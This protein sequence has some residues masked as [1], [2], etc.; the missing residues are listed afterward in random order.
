MLKVSIVG[1]GF[2]GKAVD[3]GFTGTE[4]MIIDPLYGND[5]RDLKAFNPNVTFV[6]VPTPMGENGQI[7]SSIV[8]NTV[9]YL[10]EKVIGLI[11]IKSTVTPDV[12]KKLTEGFGSERVIYNPEF[13]TEKNANE[14]FINPKMHIFGGDYTATKKLEEIYIQYSMCKPCQVFHMSA[15]DASFVKYGINCFLAS[16]VLW[17]NQ[18]YD[19]VEAFGGN[20][21]KI[22]NAIGS[23]GR[24]TNSHTRVPGFDGK[25]GYG[26]ACFPK[27]TSAF[28]SFAESVSPFTVLEHIIETNNAYRVHYEK[29][30]REKAQ[31]V[32]YG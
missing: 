9:K 28:A 12:V 7:D 29:D 14:D 8:E 30:E 23:D 21:R 2:V 18:F 27:D 4:K 3:Y 22:V 32:K 25:R 15:P 1:H 31:N 24:V 13:L 16:K 17:F 19:V 20:F 5:I 11:V 6:C 10:K 26:G